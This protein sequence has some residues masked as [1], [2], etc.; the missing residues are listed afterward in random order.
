MINLIAIITIILTLA[1]ILIIKYF[2]FNFKTLESKSHSQIIKLTWEEL[3][4]IYEKYPKQVKYQRILH[5]DYDDIYV[6][7]KA[8]LFYDGTKTTIK[9]YFSEKEIKNAIRIQ[10]SFIDYIYFLYHYIFI[11]NNKKINE[12]IFK[13]MIGDK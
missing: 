8:L 3:C 5:P 9:R 1:I 12:K 6:E 4:T 2:I 10:L 7:N 13:E 11:K